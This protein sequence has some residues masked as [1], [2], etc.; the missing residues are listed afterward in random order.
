[1]VS[2]SVKSLVVEGTASSICASTGAGEH[3]VRRYL[4]I[5]KNSSP[6]RQLDAAP[7]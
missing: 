4:Y 2:F 1:M 5:P 3:A 6:P 7:R